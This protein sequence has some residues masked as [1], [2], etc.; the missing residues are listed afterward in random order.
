MNHID[1]IFLSLKRFCSPVVAIRKWQLTAQRK[2]YHNNHSFVFR[3]GYRHMTVRSGFVGR[4]THD[5]GKRSRRKRQ[6]KNVDKMSETQKQVI[7]NS[8]AP[9]ISSHACKRISVDN[10]TEHPYMGEIWAKFQVR[11]WLLF[12]TNSEDMLHSMT[13]NKRNRNSDRTPIHYSHF[14]SG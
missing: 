8:C 7:A 13:S 14:T 5:L 10:L 1:Q 11:I 2:N 9:E 12:T 6:R 3:S 4:P